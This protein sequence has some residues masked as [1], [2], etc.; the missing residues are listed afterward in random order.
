MTIQ[1]KEIVGSGQRVDQL[2]G[3][4]T[5]V[6]KYIVWDDQH[7]RLFATDIEPFLTNLGTA[8]VNTSS[9]LERRVYTPMDNQNRKWG[10]ELHFSTQE[11]NSDPDENQEDP[12]QQPAIVRY[13][14][15]EKSEVAELAYQDGDEQG[16][17]TLPIENAAGDPF[18]PPVMETKTNLLIV[19]DKNYNSF[20]PL[21]I[22]KF[23]TTTNVAD[24]T[25]GGVKVLAGK[26]VV[27]QLTVDPA[28]KLD[29]SS[30]DQVHYEIEVTE[31]NFD[32]DLVNW[33]LS[34]LT[35]SND[36]STKKR[37]KYSNI[38]SGVS[39]GSEDDIEVPDPQQLNTDG[40]LYTTGEKY[41]TYA[42]KFPA[43]WT[44]L[45]LPR[46]KDGTK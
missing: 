43:D 10:V 41:I 46:Y 7:V 25:I 4:I 30:Y 12:V 28:W 36:I 29:G 45:A 8:V 13:G 18:D 33:G 40:T 3:S 14:S 44:P 26:G 9:I 5:Y 37:I 11:T 31:S 35:T 38:N 32:R 1:V 21:N 2:D 27:R 24:I 42:T 16:T 22:T 39:A 20:D 6:F 34:Y 15:I 19:I 17:P 23:K